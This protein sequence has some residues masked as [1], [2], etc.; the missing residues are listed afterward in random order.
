MSYSMISNFRP[1]QEPKNGFIGKADITIADGL[2]INNISVFQKEDGSRSIAF[3]QFGSEDNKRSY[4]I[5]ASK[6]AH[7]EMLAVVNMAV[8]AP[9]HFGHVTGDQFSKVKLEVVSGA[10]VDSPYM[11]GIYSVKFGDLLTL[12]GIATRMY[13]GTDGEKHPAVD[14]PAVLNEEGKVDLYT[15]KD[16]KSRAN[17]QF[18]MKKHEWTDKDGNQHEFNYPQ[19]MRIAVFVKRKELMQ[20]QPSLDDQIKEANEKPGKYE[21]TADAPAKD[22]ER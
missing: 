19:D 8:D 9:N 22:M 3:A 4:V 17:R 1:A 5:P 16:G 15:D 14:M 6:E 20:E 21:K 2:T 7:A 12:N 18:E 11:D 10:K 13:T